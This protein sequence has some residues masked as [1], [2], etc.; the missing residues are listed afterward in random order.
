M[1]ASEPSRYQQSAT[2]QNSAPDLTDLAK[3]N[4]DRV[5]ASSIQIRQVLVKDAG[6]LVELKRWVAKE[7]TDSGQV[8]G[9]S[10]LSEQAI[11]DRLDRDAVFRSVATRLLQRYG[12]LLP[13]PNPDSNFAKE[14]EFVLKERARRLVQIEAQEDSDSL[15]PRR[16]NDDVERTRACNPEQSNDC[17]KA[18]SSSSATNRPTR[19]GSQNEASPNLPPD[20]PPSVTPPRTLRTDF[21]GEGGLRDRSSAAEIELASSSAKSSSDSALPSQ[22]PYL[23]SL[24]DVIATHNTPSYPDRKIARDTSEYD[25]PARPMRSNSKQPAAAQPEAEAAPVKMVRPANPYADVPSLYDMYVQ[26]A[27]S[28]RP[29][30]RFGIDIFRNTAD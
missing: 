16:T 24:D 26:A 10:D 7:A 5:A 25:I 3:D 30:E 15:Q 21:S 12:Y 29:A 9:D 28:Q 8:V 11:F 6:L 20:L 17:A 22:T 4:L 1:Q 14:Q 13:S 27:A 19:G 2:R 18:S 23:A